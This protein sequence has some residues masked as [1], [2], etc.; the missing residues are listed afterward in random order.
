MITHEYT[1]GNPAVSHRDD[2]HYTKATEAA[3]REGIR[4]DLYMIVTGERWLIGY[5][6]TNGIRVDVDRQV[7]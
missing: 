6:H 1:L 7:A 2:R 4:A 5:I 3:V